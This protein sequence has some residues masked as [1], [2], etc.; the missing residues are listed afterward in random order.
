MQ[1]KWHDR[2][3]LYLYFILVKKML[4]PVTRHKIMIFPRGCRIMIPSLSLLESRVFWSL[5]ASLAVNLWMWTNPK[6]FPTLARLS[7]FCS[8]LSTN[9]SISLNSSGLLLPLETSNKKD[10]FICTLFGSKKICIRS[11]DTKRCIFI[12]TTFLFSSSEMHHFHYF[13]GCQA[14]GINS[15]FIFVFWAFRFLWPSYH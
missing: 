9:T 6:N 8:S 11:Q 12:P 10:I 4:Y 3:H 14:I 2:R 5:P 7:L 13:G 1:G 15:S